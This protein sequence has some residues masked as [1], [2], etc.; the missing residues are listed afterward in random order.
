MARPKCTSPF[1]RWAGGKTWL[2]GFVL[3]LTENLDFNHYY[4]PFVG[5][6]A[7]F[8]ALHPGEATISD[9]NEELIHTYITLREHTEDVIMTLKT[10]ENTKDCYYQTRA[11]IRPDDDVYMCARFIYLNRTSYNGLYRVNNMGMYNVPYGNRRID[12]VKEDHIREVS[13]LLQGVDIRSG[14]FTL[15]QNEIQE[16]DLVFLDPP[17]T[18]SHNQNGF[19]KYNQNLFQLDD[20][21]RLRRMI[22]YI[23]ARGGY[24]I[25]TNA[26]HDTIQEIFECG[27]QRYVLNRHSTIGGNK[28]QRGHV[29]EYVFTNIVAGCEHGMD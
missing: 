1:L 28:A 29:D 11:T 15:Y 17:Y 23:K 7:I 14:D 8:F 25:L 3:D 26:A 6:G 20:Q 24:Y 12:F 2:T 4:E 22:D 21:Y 27:D 9:S 13:R 5:S 19:I 10:F 16:G 18:I